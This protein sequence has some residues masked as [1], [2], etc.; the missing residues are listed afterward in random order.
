[1]KITRR[2][3]ILTLL[4]L[5]AVGVLAVPQYLYLS[6]LRNVPD[7]RLPL[8]DPQLSASTKST[9]W[10]FL[11]GDGPP[12]IIP[13]SPYGFTID[14]FWPAPDLESHRMSS[15]DYRLLGEA[16]RSV[17]FRQK[18]S[19]GW[20]LANAAA[21]IWISRNWTADEAL[22]T[23]LLDSYFGHGFF[24]IEAAS[25]GYLDTALSEISETQ[26]LYLL[27]IR[28]APSRYDPWCYP[29]THRKRFEIF[30]ARMNISTE[31]ERIAVSPPPEQACERQ[32]G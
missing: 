16:A 15:A 14:F 4:S 11:G 25:R 28:A 26:V 18:S 13:R 29:E 12:E 10:R 17:M 6:G 8:H 21:V 32:R 19:G 23:V 27:V 2:R 7:D 1:M 24:G 3:I 9:Y 30:A 20:H 22:S 31:Y 5:T